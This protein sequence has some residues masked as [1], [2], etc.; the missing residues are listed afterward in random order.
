MASPMV[1]GKCVKCGITEEAV[2]YGIS[3]ETWWHELQQHLDKCLTEE[4]RQGLLRT[5]KNA[6]EE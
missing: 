4:E 3:T 6:W 1:S 5:T 2:R